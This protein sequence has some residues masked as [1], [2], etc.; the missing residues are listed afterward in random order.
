MELQVAGLDPCAALSPEQRAQLG[1]GAG[2]A[3]GANAALNGPVCQW[4]RFP[5][6]PQDGYLIAPDLRHD[7]ASALGTATGARAVT[8]SGFPAVE[9]QV[10]SA[11]PDRQC[12]VLVDVATGQNLWVQYDYDGSTVPM[13]RE[14]ACDKARAAAEMAV[15]TLVER[16][17]G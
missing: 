12:V 15:R 1:V 9:T 6:E 11:P 3:S 2:R 7:A 14:L 13:T 16:A 17:G 8:V 10:G 4:T 5:E